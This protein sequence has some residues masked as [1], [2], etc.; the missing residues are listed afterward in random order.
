MGRATHEPSLLKMVKDLVIKK[1]QDDRHSLLFADFDHNATA[2]S[3]NYDLNIQNSKK[4]V[5]HVQV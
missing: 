2:T 4:I 3:V 5:Q 1:L